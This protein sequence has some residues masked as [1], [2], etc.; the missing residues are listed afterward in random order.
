M[1]NFF[2]NGCIFQDMLLAERIGH[3]KEVDGLFFLK[4]EKITQALL[5]K[6]IL[7]KKD[8]IMRWHCRSGH[9]NFKYLKLLFPSLFENKR[10]SD[11]HCE[12][13]EFAKYHRVSY[14]LKDYTLTSPFTLIHSDVWGP[15][16]IQ[17]VSGARWFVTFMD[18]HTHMSWIY[19]LKKKAEVALVF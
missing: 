3:G 2:P 12:V 16:R 14:P 5:A 17:T 13:C 18:D 10:M 19:L 4:E 8:E 1:V 15:S 6:K 7:G 9:P 11:F